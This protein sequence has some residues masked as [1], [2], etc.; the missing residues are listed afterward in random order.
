MYLIKKIIGF[1]ITPLALCG[2]MQILGLGLLLRDKKK[3]GLVLC[4][5]SLALLTLCSMPLI[6]EAL[7]RP[8]E[9]EKVSATVPQLDNLQKHAAY[10]VVLSGGFHTTPKYSP[11]TRLGPDSLRRLLDGMALAKRLPQ[12]VLLISGAMLDSAD[13]PATV[14]GDLALS[15]G[16][17]PAN[18]LLETQGKTTAEQAQRIQEMIGEASFYLVTSA[19]HMPRALA[20]FEAI[21]MQPIPY[22]CDHIVQKPN[23][24]WRGFVPSIYGLALTNAAL[25]EY[26]GRFYGWIRG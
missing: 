7:M 5:L 4:A 12:A 8:L 14:M 2:V 21:G 26:V 1:F 23:I 20:H 9:S 19:N 18:L 17:E 25:H 16:W 22:P 15:L 11:A 3:W 6:G 13:Q 10:V 24:G